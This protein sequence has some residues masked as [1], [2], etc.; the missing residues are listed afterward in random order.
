MP[1]VCNILCPSY[2]NIW[3]LKTGS[4]RYF[5]CID[6]S[7]TSIL[8]AAMLI[9]PYK[10]KTHFVFLLLAQRFATMALIT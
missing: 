8:F 2:S 6:D 7:I 9:I 1:R 10:I 5:R 3:I 4:R